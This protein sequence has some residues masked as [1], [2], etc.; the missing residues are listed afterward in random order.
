MLAYGLLHMDAS[1]LADQ[2]KIMFI[3]HVQTLGAV[4]DFTNHD[5][6]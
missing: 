6:Q 5:D 1:M 4:R 2:Q 3:I